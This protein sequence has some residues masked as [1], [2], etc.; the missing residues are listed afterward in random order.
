MGFSL[1]KNIEEGRRDLLAGRATFRNFHSLTTA[2]LGGA[3]PV[4]Q[5]VRFG[6]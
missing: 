4:E 5:F 6:H 2:E 3:V 1:R